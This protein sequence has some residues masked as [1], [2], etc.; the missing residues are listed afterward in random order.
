MNLEQFFLSVSPSDR[1]TRRFMTDEELDAFFHTEQ[2]PQVSAQRAKAAAPT[3]SKPTSRTLGK[4]KTNSKDS[5]APLASKPRGP[6]GGADRTTKTINLGDKHQTT[7]R[8]ATNDPGNDN[9]NA[10]KNAH[11][12]PELL[13]AV[14]QG[15]VKSGNY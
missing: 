7:P 4:K 9:T 11:V 3:P 2:V 13:K 5:K 6:R 8:E 15:K 10:L 12:T 14:Q 1:L